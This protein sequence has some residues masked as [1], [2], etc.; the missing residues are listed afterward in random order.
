MEVEKKS[1][2]RNFFSLILE[3]G[4]EL[5]SLLATLVMM[6]EDSQMLMETNFQM[7]NILPLCGIGDQHVIHEHHVRNLFT[8]H[9]VLLP[10]NQI[11]IKI[12]LTHVARDIF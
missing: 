5:I 6:E 3:S 1:I 7:V 12:I 9:A 4:M 2:S 11:M 8:A 10:I